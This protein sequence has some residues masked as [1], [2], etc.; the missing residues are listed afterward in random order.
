[1]ASVCADISN[2]TEST[3]MTLKC[4]SESFDAIFDNP[5]HLGDLPESVKPV[6]GTGILINVTGNTRWQPFAT[7]MIKLLGKCLTEGTLYVEGLMNVSFVMA[8]W[9]LL[10]YGDAD[11]HMVSGNYFMLALWYII[12]IVCMMMQLERNTSKLMMNSIAVRTIS[13]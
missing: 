8:A 6:D 1:M 11:L 13:L 10:C 4:F 3:K 7:W 5:A 9:S 2:I 12:P